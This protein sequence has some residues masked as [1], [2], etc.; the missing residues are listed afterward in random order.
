MFFWFYG[1]SNPYVSREELPLVLWLQGGPGAGGTGYGSFGEIG[2][3]DE[4][5]D[6]RNYAWTSKV[7]LLFIDNPVGAGYSYVDNSSLLTSD[8]DEI[9]ADLLTMHTMLYD[10]YSWFSQLTSNSY[11]IFSESYGG[12][13]TAVFAKE[14]HKA[15]DNGTLSS[16]NLDGVLLGDSWI[17]GVSYVNTWPDYLK[18]LSLL[19]QNEF[20]QLEETA[21][22]CQ[23]AVDNEEWYNATIMLSGPF[24]LSLHKSKKQKKN[25]LACL[26]SFVLCLFS[27][28]GFLLFLFCCCVL[29]IVADGLKWNIKL[30]I[31][32]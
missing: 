8:V 5:L 14:L 31:L 18:S 22:E 3:L 29:I 1:S 26:W 20:S 28:F 10:E 9:A 27:F 6:P 7:N 25:I 17:Q 13:M 16:I 2:P 12:K 32:L 4:Y 24:S 11:Y 23:D 19:T 15:I 30:R 21:N